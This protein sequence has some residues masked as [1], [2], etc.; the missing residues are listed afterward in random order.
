MSSSH[1]VT[2]LSIIP[3]FVK[4]IFVRQD[5]KANVRFITLII[6]LQWRVVII[7]F[8]SQLFGVGFHQKHFASTFYAYS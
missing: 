1:Y 5:Q 2:I 4:A 8:G 7:I 3:T 6:P